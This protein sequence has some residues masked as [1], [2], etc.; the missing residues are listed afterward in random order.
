MKK[1]IVL[2]TL[3]MLVF[4]TSLVSCKLFGDKN[5]EVEGNPTN[6]SY[7]T[8]VYGDNDLS[9]VLA[10]QIRDTIQN[11]DKITLTSSSEAKKALEIVV[12]KTDRT[13]SVTAYKKL[14]KI[15]TIYDTELRYLI[16]SDGKNVAIA[17]DVD[18]YDT[19]A[20]ANTVL[21]AF[22]EGYIKGKDAL[23]FSEGVLKSGTI[24]YLKYQS[25][26]DEA[27]REEK[28]E[29]LANE[30]PAEYS[31]EMVNALKTLYSI[32]SSDVVTWF[33][34]LYEPSICICNGECQKTKYCGGGGFY[35]SNSAR[36]TIGY[37][38]DVESTRQALNF[39]TGSG[40]AEAMGGTSYVDFV[41]AEMKEQIIHFVK[42]LQ[43]ENGYFYHP[44]WGMEQTDSQLSRRG[45][46]LNWAT[47]ILGDFGVAPKYDTPNGIKGEG[48]VPAAYIGSLTD[49]LGTSSIVAVSKIVSATSTSKVP[50]HLK[51]ETSFRAYLNSLP[52][53]TESYEVGNELAAQSA[54]ILARDKELAAANAGYSLADIAI[55]WLNSKQNPTTGTW[56]E[57][58][59]YHATNGL[60]KISCFY[61]DMGAYLPYAE[62]AVA[63]A[64]YSMTTDEDPYNVCCIYNNW[65]TIN[66]V[67]ENIRTHG[68]SSATQEVLNIRNLL[69][70]QG[71]ESIIAS[72]E[73]LALF[74]KVDGSFSYK[75]EYSS[76]TSQGMP[77][78]VPYTNEGDVNATDICIEGTLNNLFRAFG[79]GSNKIPLLGKSD[80]IKYLTIIEELQPVIKNEIEVNVDYITFDDNKIGT[81]PEEVQN[82]LKSPLA[83][84]EVVKDNRGN[85]NVLHLESPADSGKANSITFN[86]NTA[87]QKC[88]VFE[89]DICIESA[90]EGYI[91]QLTMG[92]CYMLAFRI[93]DGKLNIWDSSNT[94]STAR[95]ETELGIAPNIGEWFNIKIEYYVGD[96]DN[97]R[98]IAYYNGKAV[99]VSNNYYDNA[100][101]K[102]ET[103]TGKPSQS[104]TGVTIS[105]ISSRSS[106]ILIDNVALYKSS[107]IYS[108]PTGNLYQNVDEVELSE[109][110][111]GFDSAESETDY[112]NGITVEGGYINSFNGGKGLYFTENGKVLLPI[113]RR[114]INARCNFY[115]FDIM[116]DPST[117]EGTYLDLKLRED[118]S[119]RNAVTAFRIEVKNGYAIIESVP[120]G[121]VVETFDN[122]RIPLGE[123]FSI[124]FEYFERDHITL[125]YVNGKLCAASEE[126]ASYGKQ[127]IPGLFEITLNGSDVTIA[128]DNIKAEKN[129]KKAADSLKPDGDSNIHDFESTDSDLTL[130]GDA[131]IGNGVV[132]IP[133][134]GALELPI[135][136]IGVVTNAVIASLD[137]KLLSEG[138][139]GTWYI[140]FTDATGTPIFAIG[141]KKAN[142]KVY[143]SEYSVSGIHN[144]IFHTQN[145]G[146]ALFLE[147]KLYPTEN[148]A[149]IYVNEKCVAISSVFF[150][151]GALAR[152]ADKIKIS[153]L[154]GDSTLTVDNICC[155]LTYSL[156]ESH[157]DIYTSFEDNSTILDFENAMTHK[158]PALVTSIYSTSAKTRIEELIIKGKYSKVLTFGTA[159]GGNDELRIGVIERASGYNKVVF[160]AD[161]YTNFI[162]CTSGKPQYHIYFETASGVAYQ[163]R[164]V[165]EN[166][167]LT[168]RDHDNTTQGANVQSFIG[169]NE[170]FN[171]RIVIELGNANTFKAICY[172]NGTKLFESNHY[173]GKGE[174]KTPYS[175]IERVRFYTM[176]AMT[177]DISFDN[178]TFAQMANGEEPTIPEEKSEAEILPI[179]GG[180][181]GVVVLMHDDGDLVSAAILDS[182][183]RKYSIRGNVAL[184]VDRVYDVTSSTADT[185]KVSSWQNLLNSGRWQITSHSKTHDWWGTDNANGMITDE[186]VN[187]QKILRELF[188]GQRVLTFA[189]PGFSAYE[190]TYSLG[191][192]YGIA[193]E[194]VSQ[195][196]V[197]GRYFGDGGAFEIKGTEWEFVIAESIG[198]SY[199]NK[200]LSTIDDA[201]N[202]KMAIIFMHNV[203]QDTANV[204]S[205][206]VT[207]SHMSA[208]AERISGYVKNGSVWNAFYEDAVLYLKEVESAKV[209]VS[210]IGDDISVT[211]VDELPD[212]I[213]NYPLTVRL[214]VP[215]THSAVKVTQGDNV[216]YYA[217]KAVDGKW[218][219]DIDVI[220][221]GVEAI[222]TKAE[223]TDV[224]DDKE[225]E[226]TVVGGVIDFENSATGSDVAINGDASLAISGSTAQNFDKTVT[227]DP[228]GTD[229]KV[230]GAV[231]DAI[232]TNTHLYI[233]RANSSDER[234]NYY[235]FSAKLYLDDS[236]NGA[237]LPASNSFATIDFRIKGTSNVF[238]TVNLRRIRTNKD[239]PSE[240]RGLV[241]T[242][243]NDLNT[244][245]NKN[246]IIAYNG[247]VELTVELYIDSEKGTATASYYVGENLIAKETASL[248][249]SVIGE[250]PT[251]VD[252]KYLSGTSSVTYLDDVN[253]VRS[254]TPFL[255]GND[256]DDNED[257]GDEE[258]GGNEGGEIPAPGPSDTEKLDVIDF[259]SS[260]TTSTKGG[261]TMSLSTTT[262]PNFT[263]LIE[264]VN[265][266]KVLAVTNTS[267]SNRHIRFDLDT[268]KGNNSGAYYTVRMQLYISSEDAKHNA[269]FADMDFRTTSGALLYTARFF[270]NIS[271]DG[272]V[273]VSLKSNSKTDD[274]G[275]FASGIP[276]DKWIEFE[277]VCF[278]Y[279]NESGENAVDADVLVDGVRLGG[280]KGL[281]IAGATTPITV[282]IDRFNIKTIKNVSSK[283]YIDDVIF[284]RTEEPLSAEGEE[285][286]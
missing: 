240:S 124:S 128:I 159:A 5:D 63:S 167:K 86:C 239:T 236:L 11:K 141:I 67:I 221:N 223:L 60:M 17:Y 130:Y 6:E 99:A 227:V 14:E 113:S 43:E 168:F 59:D 35:Y 104:Y 77:V 8:I 279:K 209:S 231:A 250:I 131:S 87:S 76:Y 187:S 200:T 10:E 160:D 215:A 147:I 246:D 112:P 268:T 61:N 22:L 9:K 260:E 142:G 56:D 75:Q 151:D 95:I 273:T 127:Y 36:D 259:E 211:V 115:G 41:P 27:N 208:I 51:D 161:I 94:S 261:V 105:T 193:K 265:E 28:W 190:D 3:V 249:S 158:I 122:T 286:K 70:M 272:T 228:M 216:S 62:Q 80:A 175:T 263:A 195:Y 84:L 72:A 33:A 129:G 46:D 199:L 134:N 225:N 44:Q 234:G 233:D 156:Y 96:D 242:P 171:L 26:I 103:G 2:L 39:I 176:S 205:Q 174:G 32:Y 47:K 198:Q 25:A 255:E 213:Y 4:M 37:L 45:R 243:K 237:M 275:V 178:I 143:L 68:G 192:I 189:Y 283:F 58:S 172:V 253:F 276:T 165:L 256:N 202:G 138:Q 19:R 66:N 89:S 153:A 82:G 49:R 34:N 269:N 184:I 136:A 186:V 93:A 183:Y 262:D 181:S 23:T 69:Y 219:A 125:I 244:Y 42:A 180:A 218:V 126:V 148:E 173:Y 281:T 88:Y 238:Y 146:E 245:L 52:I 24:D 91:I 50:S 179:K 162:S 226:D 13:I 139:D 185:S 220:P 133:M 217:C 232:T 170:W 206:T 224:P 107:K 247:W 90:D 280:H 241:F 177:S 121:T 188:A 40:L 30:I 55:E 111:F 164:I 29:Q 182:I 119:N 20:A 251:R 109:T 278:C 78:C 207:Y 15:D 230:F 267:S 108:V 21:E 118:N 64:L 137:L 31:E 166:D 144:T 277:M 106:S 191:E 212:D 57:A 73:K 132:K 38:P 203:C 155:E 85:G 210:S 149:Q 270:W 83:T 258:Q 101:S 16:Y 252:I 235:I 154:S 74:A 285:T 150:N 222:V 257:D 79:L 214:N 98:I 97:V 102:V 53:E 169:A 65:F 1:R 196:Y 197:S 81:I 284:A 110:V 48:S 201:A 114:A 54:Q 248:S 140:A 12:G 145:A 194:L 282:D 117:P 204:P 7:Y 152:K 264:R 157:S 135:N 274:Y 163:F 229:N 100:A 92:R 271:A 254:E 120:G 71:A 116:I 18:K 266:N 123:V